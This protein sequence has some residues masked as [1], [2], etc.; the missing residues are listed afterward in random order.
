MELQRPRAQHKSARNNDGTLRK[1]RQAAS[2]GKCNVQ[3]FEAT[4]GTGTRGC[5]CKRGEFPGTGRASADCNEARLHCPPFSGAVFPPIWHFLVRYRCRT[6]PRKKRFLPTQS[7]SRKWVTATKRRFRG[8]NCPAPVP[9]SAGQ[10]RH[11][12][13]HIN[14]L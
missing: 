2:W 4:V 11:K 10:G 3:G 8:A 5:Y 14:W 12:S 9:D 7:L 13:L 1:P 6:N